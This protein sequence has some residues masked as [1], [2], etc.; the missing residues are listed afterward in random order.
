MSDT[1][2]KLPIRCQFHGR[3]V[4][5]W[6]EDD[7]LAVLRCDACGSHWTADDRWQPLN[8]F[9]LPVPPT[10]EEL[11]E[12]LIARVIFCRDTGCEW[13]EVALAVNALRAHPDWK[14]E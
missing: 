3:P 7:G 9:G 14:A 2:R 8:G 5:R 13:N 1:E 11:K 10:L 4:D 6:R 12:E